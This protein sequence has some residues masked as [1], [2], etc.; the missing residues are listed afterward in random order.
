MTAWDEWEYDI[1]YV[2][3]EEMSIMHVLTN[4]KNLGTIIDE[5]INKGGFDIKVRKNEN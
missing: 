4:T 3:K 2:D 1:T 5:I